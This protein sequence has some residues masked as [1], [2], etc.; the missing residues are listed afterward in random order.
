METRQGALTYDDMASIAG[1]QIRRET[2][3]TATARRYVF[4]DSTPLTTHF[5]SEHLFGKC[6][7]EL[8]AAACRHY[9]LSILCE[10]DFPFVQDGTRQGPAFTARQQAWYR[11]H[12]AARG[13]PFLPIGGL[14]PDRVAAIGAHLR[15]SPL[16]ADLQ[17]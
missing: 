13:I 15:A 6:A 12:L 16:G 7:P 8:E 4:C 9:D 10:L 14:L 11:T 2:R 17:S 5:Y 3:A 1:E